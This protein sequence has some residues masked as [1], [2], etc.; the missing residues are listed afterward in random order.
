MDVE[1]L[2]G[3]DWGVIDDR[4]EDVERPL[5]RMATGGPCRTVGSSRA[6]SGNV[7]EE[8]RGSIADSTL[9][10]DVDRRDCGEPSSAGTSCLYRPSVG[11]LKEPLLKTLSLAASDGM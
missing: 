7:E 3:V 4:E 9:L 10:F 1:G 6:S 11:G 2:S 5:S 8:C